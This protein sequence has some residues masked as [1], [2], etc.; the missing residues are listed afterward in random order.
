MPWLITVA[1]AAP[2]A[3]IFQAPI[4]RMS[5]TMLM[6][7]LIATNIIGCLESPMPRRMALTMLYPSVNTMPAEQHK[8]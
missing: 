6:T 4:M 8:I 5:R 1:S 2:K 7:V 3:P